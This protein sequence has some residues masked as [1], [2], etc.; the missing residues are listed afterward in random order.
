[1]YFIK[2]K[3][4]KWLRFCKWLNAFAPKKKQMLIQRTIEN[5]VSVV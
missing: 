3:E 2:L 1:M 5:F 4:Q